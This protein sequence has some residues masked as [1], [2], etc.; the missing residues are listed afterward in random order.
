[1]RERE[2]AERKEVE[3]EGWPNKG[4]QRLT[5]QNVLKISKGGIENSK[6]TQEN[7][8]QKKLDHICTYM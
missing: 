6:R 7:F 2:R 5:P 1:M 8:Q 4:L 3:K